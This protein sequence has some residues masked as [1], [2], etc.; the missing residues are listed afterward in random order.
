LMPD[1]EERAKWS[2]EEETPQGR[3]GVPERMTP[4][5]LRSDLARSMVTNGYTGCHSEDEIRRPMTHRK[6]KPVSSTRCR[7][8]R[9]E[10]QLQAI[11]AKIAR[12]EKDNSLRLAT[13]DHF[14]LW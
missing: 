6:R 14:I 13:Q 2:P 8:L 10:R 1:K 9:L 11:K 5:M 4:R 7:M 3:N 12:L